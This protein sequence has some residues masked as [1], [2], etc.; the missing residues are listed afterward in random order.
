MKAMYI[1]GAVE[2]SRILLGSKIGNKIRK[3]LG[4][5]YTP[6]DINKNL[7]DIEARMFE[8][9]TLIYKLYARVDINPQEEV[10]N[11]QDTL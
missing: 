7:I 6:P 11:E 8:L 3:K 9:E 2:L 10:K 5:Q 1:I 4:G